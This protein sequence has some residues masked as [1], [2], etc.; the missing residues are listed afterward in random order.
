MPA[1]LPLVV[2]PVFNA[3]AQLDACVASLDRSLPAGCRVLIVDDASGDPQIE[4]MVR[5]WGERSHLDASY[6]RRQHRL[7]IA[8]NCAEAIRSTAPEDIVLLNSDAITTAG[9]LQQLTQ[10]A[11]RD[12]RIA[13]ITPWSNHAGL[14][15]FLGLGDV[16]SA[17]EN[18]D[19]VTEAAASLEWPESPDLPAV[20]GHCLFLRRAALQQLGGLDA[21]TFSGIRVLDDYCLR[22]RAMGW[23]NVLWPGAFVL[24]QGD[25]PPIMLAG[26][27]LS[28]GATLAESW[29]DG[30]ELTRLIA[31]WPEFQEQIAEFVLSDPI[32][33]L[34]QRLQAR[35]AELV[36]GGPQRDM[37]N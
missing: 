28:P 26:S 14:C 11:A 29:T 4:P 20:A 24:R 34:R 30:E 23:R 32:N 36:R 21:D 3:L 9:W 27:S 25:P 17:A 10:C 13:T 15:C 1:T 33:P 2:V 37:F 16:N 22:A 19:W 8:G 7:G 12:P 18:A 35:I 31:R 6:T 5:G